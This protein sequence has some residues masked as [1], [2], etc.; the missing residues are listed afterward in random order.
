MIILLSKLVLIDRKFITLLIENKE[1]SNLLKKNFISKYN[2]ILRIEYLY[3]FRNLFYNCSFNLA[4]KITNSEFL[5]HL[6][7]LMKNVQDP[8]FIDL[9]LDALGYLFNIEIK[10]NHKNFELNNLNVK[11]YHEN[12]VEHFP[13]YL[14][15][16]PFRKIFANLD[17][18]ELLES[19]QTK[20]SGNILK[21]IN[22]LLEIL[23]LENDPK[24]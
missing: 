14:N 23:E 17:G 16:N 9:Y 11:N 12:F 19:L 4:S 10:N 8:I 5:T 22:N 21:R 6:S 18:I 7:H 3:F 20:Y 1:A 15:R 24:N 13:V 2:R